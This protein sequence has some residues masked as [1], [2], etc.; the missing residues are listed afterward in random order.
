MHVLISDNIPCFFQVI[1]YICSF[2]LYILKNGNFKN[3]V[4]IFKTSYM[5]DLLP[6]ETPPEIWLQMLLLL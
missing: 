4:K 2:T 5:Q 3:F 6:S 1:Q